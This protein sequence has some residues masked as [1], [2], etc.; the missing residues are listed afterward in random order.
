MKLLNGR[1]C[2]IAIVAVCLL[3]IGAE[4]SAIQKER[5]EARNVLSTYQSSEYDEKRNF[6][7][8]CRSSGRLVDFHS[9]SF[10]KYGLRVDRT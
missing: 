3:L 10:V 6:E 2:C 1:G 9:E 4:G 7:A 5:S 8:L